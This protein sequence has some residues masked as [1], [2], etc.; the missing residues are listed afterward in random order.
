MLAVLTACGGGSGSGG[1]H[2]LT[3]SPALRVDGYTQMRLV[4]ADNDALNRMPVR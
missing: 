1:A 4:L 2:E 3:L